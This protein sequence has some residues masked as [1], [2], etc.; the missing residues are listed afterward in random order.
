MSATKKGE[1][2]PRPPKKIEYEIRFATANARKGWQDLVGTIRNS[3]A[4]TWDVLT[5]AP[6]AT[7]PTTYHLKGDLGTIERG[8]VTHERWQHKPTATGTA[9]IWYYVHDRTVFLEQV[10][11][12]HPNETK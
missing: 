12:S 2:V 5:R 3:M 11:T 9:R 6:L 4:E 7:T 10:H 8:G 1:L